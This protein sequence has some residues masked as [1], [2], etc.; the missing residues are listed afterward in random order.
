MFKNKC[1]SLLQTDQLRLP[2]FLL[3][4]TCMHGGG[5][6]GDDAGSGDAA[7]MGQRGALL[8]YGPQLCPTHTGP[9]VYPVSS[10]RPPVQAQQS[11][12]PFPDLVSEIV[13]EWISWT[14][15]ESPPSHTTW[16]R[17]HQNFKLKIN[18]TFLFS[19]SVIQLILWILV[20]RLS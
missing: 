4:H 6:G 14:Q 20:I 8:L 3:S 10:S 11:S 18:Y 9:S 12:L 5:A 7:G 17:S 1:I 2:A 15:K 13:S 19:V 16:L